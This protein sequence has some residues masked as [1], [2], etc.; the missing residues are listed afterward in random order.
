MAASTIQSSGME[1]GRKPARSSRRIRCESSGAETRNQR[2]AKEIE[3]SQIHVRLD[4]RARRPPARPSAKG[5]HTQNYHT[6]PIHDAEFR[7][8]VFILVHCPSV[9]RSKGSSRS[10]IVPRKATIGRF[11]RNLT[12]NVNKKVEH[13]TFERL[14]TLTTLENDRERS[15][16]YRRDRERK[17]GQGF[18]I[19]RRKWNDD[20]LHDSSGSSLAGRLTK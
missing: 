15:A 12:S 8:Y 6:L 7:I 13:M 10:K 19:F 17:K 11:R 4:V 2:R 18:E 20:I 5:R 1:G 16:A 3:E 9:R 14:R